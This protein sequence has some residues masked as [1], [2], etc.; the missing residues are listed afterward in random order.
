MPIHSSFVA[1]SS[2]DA[3]SRKHA[4]MCERL[5]DSTDSKIRRNGFQISRTINRIIRC[6][7][8]RFQE[9]GRCLFGTINGFLVYS[10]FGFNIFNGCPFMLSLVHKSSFH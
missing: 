1:I 9:M 3:H 10:D 7:I 5:R 6:H 8:G 2:E 4:G